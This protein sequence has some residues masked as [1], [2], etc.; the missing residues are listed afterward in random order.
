MLT[1]TYVND[2]LG[3]TTVIHFMQIKHFSVFYLDHSK[4]HS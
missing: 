4:V 1:L 3:L 2:V